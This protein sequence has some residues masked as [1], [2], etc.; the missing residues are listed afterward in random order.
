M[1]DPY[2]GSDQQNGTLFQVR[3]RASSILGQ[4]EMHEQRRFEAASAAVGRDAPCSGAYHGYQ[5]SGATC[6]QSDSQCFGRDGFCPSSFIFMSGCA[7]WN[8]ACCSSG[9]ADTRH[10][11]PVLKALPFQAARR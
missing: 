5:V 11:F 6:V 8:P 7:A 2:Q 1:K 3:M 9:A 10:H 4:L